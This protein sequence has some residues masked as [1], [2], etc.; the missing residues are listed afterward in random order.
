MKARSIQLAVLQSAE[1][2]HRARCWRI[3]RTDGFVLAVTDHDE[4]LVIDSVTYRSAEGL[5]P[6]A[7]SQEAS[8]A[9]ANSEASGF[10]KVGGITEE[11]VYAGLWDGASIE[12]F[13][14]DYTDLSAGVMLLQRGSLGEFEVGRNT[15]KA[16]MRGLVQRLQKPVGRV[17]TKGCPWVFGDPSTCRVDLGPLTETGTITSVESQRSFADSSRVEPADYFGAGLMTITSGANEGVSVEIYS[18]EE[19]QFTLHLPLPY[20]ILVGDTY[21]VVPGCR[22]RFQEDCRGKWNNINNFGGFPHLPG[23]DKVLGLGGTEGTS[24]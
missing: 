17:V 9:V 8:A 22:K 13:E 16:E 19:G 21:S 12:I 10:L 15:F 6:S 24:L 5:S 1:T 18:Y 7:I 20:E 11:D 3:E 4:D 2:T 14:V 23:T